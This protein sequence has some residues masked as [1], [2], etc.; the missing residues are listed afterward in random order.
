[1]ATS[2]YKPQRHVYY[3]PIDPATGE[4]ADEPVYTYKPW[5]AIY[6]RMATDGVTVESEVFESADDLASA[7]SE[8]RDSMAKLGMPSSH[9]SQD[10]LKAM[11]EKARAETIKARKVAA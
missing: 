2:S 8:W 3:G 5:P 7:G 4:R 9:P 6:Y 11:R 1:M 10:E